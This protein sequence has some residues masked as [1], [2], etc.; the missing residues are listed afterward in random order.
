LKSL[1]CP[2]CG[3]PLNIS[4]RFVKMVTCEFCDHVMLLKDDGLDPTGQVAK[5]AQLPS[6][7]Y[8]DA[9]GTI[10]GKSFQV[11]GR[12]RYQ[13]DAG[14]WDEW[15]ISLEGEQP[16]WLVED[17]GTYT[18]YHKATL[19]SPLP[20]FE[21]IRVGSVIKVA[22]REMFVTE[23]GE[24]NIVG[25]EGQLAFTILPGEEVKYVDGNSGQDQISIEYT[26]D[27]IEY[28]VG[29]PIEPSELVVEEED[30]W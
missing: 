19:T 28:L 14:M 11:L 12:L 2:S 16:G 29:R 13:Y 22:D 30:Y 3:A 15:F 8:L 5:L 7:L 23:K 25:G 17:E 9:T 24:A 21:E 6:P 18:L 1:S 27:E 10:Q 4:N 20:P 26:T